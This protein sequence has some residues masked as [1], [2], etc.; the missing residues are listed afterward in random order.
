MRHQS[1]QNVVDSLGVSKKTS[2]IPQ[3]FVTI[4]LNITFPRQPSRTVVLNLETIDPSSLV[5]LIADINDSD[6]INDYKI[7]KI[8]HAFSLVDFKK[9]NVV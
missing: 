9:S 5:R 8:L 7:F 4:R 3:H 1:D 2:K 6:D